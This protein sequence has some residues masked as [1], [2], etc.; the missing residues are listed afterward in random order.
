MPSATPPTE[1]AT[2]SIDET[3][4]I[5]IVTSPEDKAITEPVMLSSV[6]SIVTLR[7]SSTGMNGCTVS[8]DSA[9]ILSP[10]ST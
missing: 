2:I 1:S 5:S 9:T 3:T 8:R 4:P 10:G 6:S 7:E